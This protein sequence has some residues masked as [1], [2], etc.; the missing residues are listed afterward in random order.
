MLAMALM[1]PVA[2]QAF[3]Q[4][5]VLEEI[6]VTAQ[7]REQSLQEVPIAV[8]AFTG[9]ELARQNITNATQ[10]LE[11]TPNVSFTEDGQSGSRGMGIAVR[12]IN[13]LVSGENAFINSIGLYIDEFSVTSVPNQVANP[14]LPDMERVEILRGPQGTYFGRNSV[15]G[16]LN[17]TTKAPTDEFEGSVRL[18]AESY[19]DAGE[20]FNITGIL[21]LP[22]SETFAL[23]GVVYYEDSSGLVDNACATGASASS[24][25]A[26]AENGFTPNGTAD[27]GH[28]YVM[29]RLK[30][31]A[32]ISDNTSLDFTVIYNDESQGT[33]EN[34]PSGI[35]DI[36]SA[37]SFGL[38]AALDPGTGFWPNNRNMLSHDQQESNDLETL[39][40]I[41]NI[42]HTFAN[43]MTLHWITGII[44]A[45]QN[46]LF[47]N[48][49]V[50]GA[51]TLVRTNLYEGDS[52][53]TEFRLHGGN[54]S[55]DWIAGVLYATDEQ[56]Q[57]NNV[58][59]ASQGT[60]TLGGVGWLPPFPEGLGL[61]L[62]SKSFNVDSLAVFVDY[63]WHASDYWDVTIGGRY[64]EDDVDNSLRAFGIGP[65]P[66]C[67]PACL[68]AGPADPA[69]F[70]SFVNSPRPVSLASSSFTDFAPRLA[71]TYAAS[72][73]VNI[74][75]VISKGYKAGGNSV[76]NNT[77]QPGEPAFSVSFEPETLIN[78][79]VGVKSELLDRRL[80]LNATAFFLQW[81]DLQVE[82][83]R[84]LTPGDLS[85][86][87]EQ[88]V[89]IEEAEALGLEV[90]FVAL[91]SDSLTV[92]GS[93]G[94]LDTEITSDS[95]AEITGGATVNLKGL[96]IPKAPENTLN[97]FAELRL[98]F[99]D[100][101]WWLRGEVISRDGQYSDVEGLT[102]LQTR[103]FREV[104]PGEFPYLS[105]SY[106]V[107]NLRGGIDW[108]RVSLMVYVQNA[109]DEEYY[110]GTQENF[111][112]SGIRLRPHPRVIGGAVNISF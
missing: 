103:S 85:S 61:A 97:L 65:G 109:G 57:E 64:T 6:T 83:F 1:L 95:T 69:F 48:D 32:D 14:F 76:G 67:D 38:T 56:T 100:N 98:P 47:D 19:D 112:I 78:Y 96:V 41:L 28:E 60:H 54:E 111:G 10:Y 13:N 70:P 93:F 51:D 79:E 24:C 63:T 37:D 23:R 86:N 104:G 29:V 12:G 92:G 101:E 71:V 87:F 74:Y 106:T 25:P 8:T 40:G 46:R 9:D 91:L 4:E 105:P 62:N 50:G 39:V 52:V 108:E 49:L 21:N 44:D 68:A 7:R 72:D 36:D 82:A 89:N 94:L 55:G 15:G 31:A 59:M 107:F 22:A 17:L 90:E 73:N 58:A 35:L 33:D 80:R 5:G 45:E 84:F 99:G 42:Q 77:N 18:G 88:A 81:E 16:A 75:G 20:Q 3:A 2:P 11:L 34:V 53:S 66:T 27:S 30:G 43:D 26:S 110:T 102:N